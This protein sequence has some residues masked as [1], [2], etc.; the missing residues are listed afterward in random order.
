[1]QPK[2]AAELAARRANWKLRCDTGAEE[3]AL[4]ERSN[5]ERS[6][7]NLR[8]AALKASRDL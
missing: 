2:Q 4:Y 5:V 6:D 7:V 1:M 8:S 3:G